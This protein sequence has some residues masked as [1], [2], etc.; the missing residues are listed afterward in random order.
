MGILTQ[1]RFKSFK[2]FKSFKSFKAFKRI[3]TFNPRP[4]Q[5][6]ADPSSGGCGRGKGEG[7]FEAGHPHL[8]PLPPWEGEE[9]QS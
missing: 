9:I 4:L 1:T 8:T 2:T 6:E 7:T 5:P 3:K